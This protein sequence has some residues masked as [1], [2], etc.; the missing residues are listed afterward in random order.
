MKY[1]ISILTLLFSFNVKAE[2][3][4]CEYE[5]SF[6]DIEQHT[7]TRDGDV[8]RFIARE[9]FN[10]TEYRLSE[11][12]YSKWIFLTQVIFH[13]ADFVSFRISAINKETLEYVTYISVFDTFGDNSLD[14]PTDT[15]TCTLIP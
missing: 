9:S 8:F 5:S 1:L 13:Q 14:M 12:K 3:Y 7:F 11:S 10:I 2:S 4:V 15:G 6:G